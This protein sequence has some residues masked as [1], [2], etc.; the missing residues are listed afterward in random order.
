[1][2][3]GATSVLE[4]KES[5]IEDSIES[6]IELTIEPSPAM[7]GQTSSLVVGGHGAKEDVT[8]VNF[9]FTSAL[10]F[11]TEKVYFAKRGEH[12]VVSGIGFGV[13]NAETSYGVFGA[14]LVDAE[15][16]SDTEL[17]LMIPDSAAATGEFIIQ[18]GADQ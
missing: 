3:T 5:A 15:V 2:L 11:D 16:L 17:S 13:L 1:M 12:V 6:S 14:D 9:V 7:I 18:Y 10:L 4:W 8:E